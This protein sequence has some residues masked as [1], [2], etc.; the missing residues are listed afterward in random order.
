MTATG[1]ASQQVIL[2]TRGVGKLFGK[3]VALNNITAEFTQGAITSIIGPNGAG[4]S[5]YFN[6]L[7]GALRPRAAASSSKAATSPGCRSIAS[8]IWASRNRSRSPTCFRS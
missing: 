7:S 4:K 6:L 5:T 8:P 3:F 2:R 1:T